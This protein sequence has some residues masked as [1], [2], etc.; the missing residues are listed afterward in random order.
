MSLQPHNW[1]PELL[2]LAYEGLDTVKR[3]DSKTVFD[4]TLLEKSYHYCKNVT[5]RHSRSFYLASSLLPRHKQQAVRALYAF[6]RVT[7]DIVDKSTGNA[8][9]MLAS[10]CRRVLTPPE[11]TEDNLVAVAWADT[12]HRYTIPR[13]YIEQF[14][15]GVARDLQKTCYATFADL[16]TYAYG[17]AATVGLMSMHITGFCGAEAIPY[18]VKLGVALQITNI[19]R[20]VGEDWQAGRLYLPTDELERFRLTE[21]DLNAEQVNDRWRDFMRFQIERN[22]QLYREAWP[23]IAMLHPDGRFA[24]ATA[25]R[26]YQ[27]ILRSIEAN[28]YNVFDRRAYVST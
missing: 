17:V 18:A 2:S 3:A 22:R 28:D 9:E 5:A 8:Q 27:Q 23:G 14:I 26:V 20:D 11:P 16:A 24:I 4:R 25:A 6:C 15:D 7:D 13:R 21:A 10:W 12:Q 19:L 1:E